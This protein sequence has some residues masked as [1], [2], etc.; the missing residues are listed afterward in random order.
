MSDYD[1]WKTG[2]SRFDDRD[3]EDDIK[4]HPTWC[5]CPG[6]AADRQAH[7]EAAQANAWRRVHQETRELFE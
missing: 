6:C 3:P 2:G 1:W 7:R 4:Y 5:G